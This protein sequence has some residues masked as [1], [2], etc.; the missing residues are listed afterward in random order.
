MAIKIQGVTVISD[1]QDLTITGYANFS[2]TGAIKVPVGTDGQRPTAAAGQIRFNSTSNTFEGYNGT[3]WGGFGGGADEVART[4]ATLALE[5]V[6][7]Y[8]TITVGNG[9]S[10]SLT[11]THNLNR[12]TV[13]VVVKEVS[14][15]Y[16]V[17]PDIDVISSNAVTLEFSTPP[18][19][20]QYAV[21]VV[22]IA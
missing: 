5:S 4:L 22:G 10:T 18:T 17:Y 9:I 14:T 21:T 20:S 12:S 19:I 16:L 11:F 6:F 1:T 3:A 8:S 7:S 13:M 15:G 2:G